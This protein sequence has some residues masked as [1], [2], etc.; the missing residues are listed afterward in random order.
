M[1]AGFG[2]GGGEAREARDFARSS[3]AVIWPWQIE[4]QKPRLIMRVTI[5]MEEATDAKGD[6]L[7]SAL[8]RQ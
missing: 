1:M 5:P 7:I 4:L 2:A 3:Q 6:G 8:V